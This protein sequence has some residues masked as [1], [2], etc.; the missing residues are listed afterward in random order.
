LLSLEMIEGLVSIGCNAAMVS[1]SLQAFAK[2]IPNGGL[3]VDHEDSR[4]DAPIQCG[5]GG[6]GV[7]LFVSHLGQG[8][9]FHTAG[10]AALGI[11]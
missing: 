7:T 2:Q 1:L 9:S 5:R 4:R 10:N 3:V 11:I 8:G 6:W